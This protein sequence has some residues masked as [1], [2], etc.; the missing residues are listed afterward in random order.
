MRNKFNGRIRKDLGSRPQKDFRCQDCGFT[1]DTPD[2]VL[3]HVKKTGHKK[4]SGKGWDY[5][6]R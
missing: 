4:I 3:A 1:F 2:E 5:G 6:A